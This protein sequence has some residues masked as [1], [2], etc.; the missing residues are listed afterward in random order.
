MSLQTLLSALQP[1]ANSAAIDAA[2]AAVD[3][4]AQRPFSVVLSVDDATKIW[5]TALIIAAAAV[6]VMMKRK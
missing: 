5:I 2:G 1:Q 4:L 3:S 6:G